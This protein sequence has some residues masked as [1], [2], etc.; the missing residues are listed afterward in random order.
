M[1]RTF[2]QRRSFSTFRFGR[3]GGAGANPK[4]L[5][6]THE[7]CAN[8]V[9]EKQKLVLN[10]KTSQRPSFAVSASQ[11]TE[12]RNPLHLYQNTSKARTHT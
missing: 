9:K 4:I 8:Y 7:I 10:K 5:N 11:Q 3:S 1:D 2:V 6:A 12:C